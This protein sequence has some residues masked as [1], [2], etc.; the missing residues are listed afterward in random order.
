MG[1]H[2][3]NSGASLIEIVVVIMVLVILASLLFPV[4][5]RALEFAHAAECVSKLRQIGVAAHAYASDNNGILPRTDTPSASGVPVQYPYNIEGYLDVNFSQA[6]K[7]PEV[8]RRTPFWCPSEKNLT[9]PILGKVGYTYAINRELNERLY[10]TAAYIRLSE[11]SSP[12]QYVIFSDA[13]YDRTIYTDT[14]QKMVD[15]T[16]VTRRHNGKPNFLYADG[17]VARF[18]REIYGTSDAEGKDPF[19]KRLWLARYKP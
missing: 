17:H 2:S 11:M 5:K 9:D 6:I 8:F 13:Y 15:M 16:R 12:G 19:Y 14:R 18:D 1:I 3:K 7:T 4:G 10:G